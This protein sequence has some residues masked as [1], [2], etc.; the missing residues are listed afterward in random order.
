MQRQAVLI[1]SRLVQRHADLHLV[2]AD[3]HRLGHHQRDVLLTQLVRQRIE[4]HVIQRVLRETG[5][6]HLL[7]AHRDAFGLDE[8]PVA[9]HR[10]R[11][12]DQHHRRAVRRRL[13]LKQLKVLR[14]DLD[15]QPH[16]PRHA[17]I[18][19]RLTPLLALRSR[20]SVAQRRTQLQLADRVPKLIRLGP[21]RTLRRPPAGPRRVPVACAL[22]H[23]RKDF[24]QGPVL[25]AL[26][27]PRR[28]P[29]LRV[30]VFVL[31]FLQ[32]PRIDH[33][34]HKGLLVGVL[35]LLHRVQRLIA[36]LQDELHHLRLRE[37]LVG[38]E[39]PLAVELAVVVLHATDV[40]P[41]V[42]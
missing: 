38:R 13:G 9:H 6:D 41:P 11:Q 32:Q 24:H 28:Q 8:P 23:V 25:Q 37:Q 42:T 30:P 40:R 35:Q 29:Q 12:I 5:P 4:P 2:V 19:A 7:H 39:E 26:E 27:H 33:R 14:P 10:P 16:A 3:A 34:L 21:V 36:V 15:R 22:L 1:R 20:N 17:S 31:V 18:L